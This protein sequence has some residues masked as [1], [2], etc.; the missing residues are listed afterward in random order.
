MRSRLDDR[1]FRRATARAQ[2][3]LE[4][5]FDTVDDACPVPLITLAKQSHR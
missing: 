1:A 4:R 2:M 3:V 5:C